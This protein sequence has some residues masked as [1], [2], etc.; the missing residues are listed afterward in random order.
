MM[1]KFGQM[2]PPTILQDAINL[3]L[4]IARDIDADAVARYEQSILQHNARIVREMED[5]SRD[6]KVQMMAMFADC[7]DSDETIVAFSD[8]SEMHFQKTACFLEML[9]L[10]AIAGK[11]PIL[12]EQFSKAFE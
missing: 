1:A 7:D 10:T 2:T 9:Q 6:A 4:A 11:D 3:G 12:P 5:Q 8:N